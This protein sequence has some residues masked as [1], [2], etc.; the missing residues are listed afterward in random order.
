MEAELQGTGLEKTLIVTPEDRHE[1]RQL[2]VFCS[3]GGPLVAVV[4][5]DPSY[6]F[7]HL[8]L[9]KERN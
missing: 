1:E 2:E 5:H 9:R 6:E 7:S 3:N 8:E 4:K